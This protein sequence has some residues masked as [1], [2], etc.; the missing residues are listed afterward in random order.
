M[1]VVLG[2][3]AKN[4]AFHGPDK[5]DYLNWYMLSL[6]WFLSQ[7]RLPFGKLCLHPSYGHF[8]EVRDATPADSPPNLAAKDPARVPVAMVVLPHCPTWKMPELVIRRYA[9][10]LQ[11]TPFCSTPHCRTVA[12]CGTCY[13]GGGAA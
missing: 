11:Y 13:T 12:S 5:W 9:C 1:G 2:V 6:Q 4:T 3:A 10:L 7:K 8:V